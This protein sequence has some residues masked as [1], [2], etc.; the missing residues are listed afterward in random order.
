MCYENTEICYDLSLENLRQ[1][2]VVE[3]PLAEVRRFVLQNVQI[4]SLKFEKIPQA[5][6]LEILQNTI[7]G[8]FKNVQP[9]A[10]PFPVANYV[11]CVDSTL[12]LPR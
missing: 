6:Q 12:E 4:E 8:L 2:L 3:L 11:R 10:H 1:G 9:V 7:V 5:T